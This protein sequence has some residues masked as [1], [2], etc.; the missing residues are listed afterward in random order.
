M[1]IKS[2]I[3][4]MVKSEK[5]F[6]DNT[7]KYGYNSGIMDF[8]GRI[9]FDYT[10]APQHLIRFG[11]EF[12]RHAYRPSVQRVR[13]INEDGVKRHSRMKRRTSAL[14]SMA[15]NSPCIWRMT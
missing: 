10:P 7:Y 14:T 1:N 9:D 3:R 6:Y 12:I 2:D 5:E 11:T 13:E 8:G 15:Q 4:E